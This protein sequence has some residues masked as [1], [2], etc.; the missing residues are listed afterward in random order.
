MRF[1]NKKSP[2]PRLSGGR[3]SVPLGERSLMCPLSV[4]ST[5]LYDFKSKPETILE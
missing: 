4:S 3:G 2:A 1:E 5:L